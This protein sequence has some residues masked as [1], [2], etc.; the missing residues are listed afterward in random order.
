MR[1]CVEAFVRQFVA[2]STALLALAGGQVFAS[3]ADAR[4]VAKCTRCTTNV[5]GA[6]S[7]DLAEREL[8]RAWSTVRTT[9]ASLKRLRASKVRNER[10]V[11][12]A[13]RERRDNQNQ[14]ALP[15]IEQRLKRLSEETSRLATEISQVD[16]RKKSQF[17]RVS[18]LN[19]TITLLPANVCRT[20]WQ[21]AIRNRHYES[22]LTL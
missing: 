19:D 22:E 11:S 10:A 9:D 13:L 16:A 15:R 21:S 20:P 5:A 18:W 6:L 17:A 3:V 14:A 12:R 7:G 1:S 8:S 4:D 2:Y